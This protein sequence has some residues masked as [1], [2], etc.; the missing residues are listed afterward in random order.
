MPRATMQKGYTLQNDIKNLNVETSN[1]K[2]QDT[3]KQNSTTDSS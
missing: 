3:Y 1:T 2:P